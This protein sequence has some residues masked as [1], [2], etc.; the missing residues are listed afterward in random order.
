MNVKQ[1]TNTITNAL[2]REARGLSTER[3]NWIKQEIIKRSSRSYKENG[4][5]KERKRLLGRGSRP[6]PRNRRGGLGSSSHVVKPSVNRK[7][8]K[9]SKG[10]DTLAVHTHLSRGSFQ[11]SLKESFIP[12]ATNTIDRGV[13]SSEFE[14]HKKGI[15]C[16]DVVSRVLLSEVSSN[17]AL[18]A[19]DRFPDGMTLVSPKGFG[20]L[21]DVES[22]QYENY[23]INKIKIHY[24]PI[25]PATQAGSIFIYF[26]NDPSTVQ[27]YT[28]EDEK[29]HAATN[30]HFMSTNVFSSAEMTVVPDDLAKLYLTDPGGNN[31]ALTTQGLLVVSAGSALPA[32]VAFGTLYATIHA[33]FEM[34]SLSHTIDLIASSEVSLF[35][36]HSATDSSA[37]GSPMFFLY[38]PTL[39]AVFRA[40]F[41]QPLDQSEE[42]IYYGAI[43][44]T[45]TDGEFSKLP[46]FYS[47]D[48]NEPRTFVT[49]Q[50]IFL[51]RFPT[52]VLGDVL[53]LFNSYAAASQ[54]SD[55]SSAALIQDGQLLYSTNYN[56]LVDKHSAI[57]I[58]T[59]TIEMAST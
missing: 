7:V 17:Y 13:R 19:G 40:W 52:H 55:S 1:K 47:I 15:R 12:L 57:A 25:V 16:V 18:G 41:V 9:D 14:Y 42:V 2:K 27:T 58:Q 33:T 53:L 51:K 49:G 36:N 48:D 21:L 43:T 3:R 6:A 59:K 26:A 56:P 11:K 22:K 29:R 30:A 23:R 46:T 31:D 10:R 44:E 24:T 28:G 4:K 45:Y 20:S 38:D 39:V 32:G 34:P 37:A 54:A 35:W 5:T 50:G 8:Y